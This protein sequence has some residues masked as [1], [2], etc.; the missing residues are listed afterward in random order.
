MFLSAIQTGTVCEATQRLDW[1]YHIE[2]ADTFAVLLYIHCLVNI[3]EVF[4]TGGSCFQTAQTAAKLSLFF[5]RQAKTSDLHT[6][7]KRDY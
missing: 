3:T 2:S 4:L 6:P 1:F 7:L 5:C